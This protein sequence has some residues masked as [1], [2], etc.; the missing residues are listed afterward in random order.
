MKAFHFIASF[1]ELP[2]Y[3]AFQ[4]FM[5]QQFTVRFASPSPLQCILYCFPDFKSINS[6]PVCSTVLS[7][8]LRV[9]YFHISNTRTRYNHLV[10][11][12]ILFTIRNFS[13]AEGFGNHNLIIL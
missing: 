6:S 9:T 12:K 4:Y 3:L 2:Q 7:I 13:S 11:D 10:A 5:L 8:C 1:Y